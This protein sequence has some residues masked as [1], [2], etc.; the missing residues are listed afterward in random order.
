MPTFSG[1]ITVGGGV[2]FVGSAVNN[3]TING[4]ATFKGTSINKG[5]ING[6]ANFLGQ[7]WNDGGTVSGG[8]V[9]D[10][11]LLASWIKIA[12]VPGDPWN[13]RKIQTY[14]VY[15]AQ[16]NQ[17][18]PMQGC[19]EINDGC[20]ADP[21]TY[22]ALVNF[23]YVLDYENHPEYC[24]QRGNNC[25]GIVDT[26][27]DP[28]TN[29]TGTATDGT[30]KLSWTP[31]TN[32]GGKSLT[33]YVVQLSTNG[34]T[35]TTVTDNISS[36]AA[37]TIT[38][39]VNGLSYVFRVAAVNE[40][41]TGKYS[42]VS[43]PF[44]PLGLPGMPTAVNGAATNAQVS[45]TWTAP[46]ST[47]GTPI[48][49]YVVQ[50]KQTGKPWKTF[51]DG[52]DTTAATVTGLE[53]GKRYVF[54]V[55]AVNAIGTSQYSAPSEELMPIHVPDEPTGVV[56]TA[57]D[58]Q[59]QLKW[60]APAFN[61]GASLTVYR[62]WFSTN[63]NNLTPVAITA[64]INNTIVVSGLTNGTPYVFSVTANNLVGESAPSLPSTSI[65]PRT[66]PDAPGIITTTEGAGQIELTWAAPVSN[67][68]ALIT[69]Y[70]I[71]FSKNNGVSWSTFN[72]TKSPNT[73]VV[74]TG[75]TNGTP[76]VFRV[77]AINVAGLG[78]YSAPS[79]AATPRTV[80]GR[81]TNLVATPGN[82][83]AS[84]SWAAPAFNGGSP[85]TDY[86]IE[87]STDGITWYG[88]TT[89][90]TATFAISNNLS[91]GV[92]YRIRLR[93]RNIAGFSASPSASVTVTPRTAPDAPTNVNGTAGNG[94]V[95]LTWSAPNFNG[96]A[97]ITDYII[98]YK[99]TTA[100]NWS[101]FTDKKSTATTG[102]V[103]GLTNGVAYEFRI[104]ARNIAGVSAFSLASLLVTPT[105]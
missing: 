105:A 64:A 37:A 57:G 31:P 27:P 71:Q 25:A 58:A 24:L 9:Y 67:G 96:G 52:T 4:N 89:E 75:L 46:A 80:P 78:T 40:I 95:N 83:L 94:R 42:D 44:V 36:A 22:R 99:A 33:D 5:T 18:H 60:S 2:T 55:A 3:G 35:W 19:P 13:F 92:A 49:D 91:N 30:V 81:P 84:L 34:T 87:R 53:N 103:T 38:G 59:V 69:D 104:A 93:A 77:A 65:T 43:S 12:F 102:T 16:A 20:Y 32:N 100:S 48:T 45:L 97:P 23:N 54:R 66:T 70:R 10:P 74:V 26:P 90:S 1:N 50:F 56:G 17:N 88:Y 28:P 72:D 21:D 86:I 82:G 51:A 98:E 79:S 39:L 62:V 73:T 29:V 68:G 101:L 11:P 47:G 14:R 76:Y 63:G 6:A 85:I 61:G 15:G 41:G 7:S 8:I